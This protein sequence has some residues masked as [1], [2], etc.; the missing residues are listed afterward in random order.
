MGASIYNDF[1]TSIEGPGFPAALAVVSVDTTKGSTSSSSWDLAVG[2]SCPGALHFAAQFVE[3][4]SA[5]PDERAYGSLAFTPSDWSGAAELHVR[6][7]IAP[8]DAPLSEVRLFV[9]SGDNFLYRSTVDTTT[10]R[11]GEWNEMVV[12]LA[13]DTT[14]DATKA[15]RVGVA[16]TLSRAGTSGIPADPPTIHFWLDDIWV[17]PS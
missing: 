6:V 3:Y 13:P 17:E 12:P 10:F 8:A 16:L 5:S 1:D 15:H 11:N 14:F 7:R 2:A 9:M 4:V